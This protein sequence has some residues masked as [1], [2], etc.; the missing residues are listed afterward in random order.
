MHKK[1]IW[2]PIYQSANYT[3]KNG[4]QR[5]ESEKKDLHFLCLHFKTVLIFSIILDSILKL[6]RGGK[7]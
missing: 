2:K 3:L 6:I 5:A 1:K 7:F 4:D